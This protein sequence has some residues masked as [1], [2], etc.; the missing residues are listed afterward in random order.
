R[1]GLKFPVG[2]VHRLLR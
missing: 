1:A 2:R